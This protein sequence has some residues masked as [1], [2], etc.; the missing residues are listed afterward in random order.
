MPSSLTAFMSRKLAFASLSATTYIVLPFLDFFAPIASSRVH[1]LK[2]A[3]RPSTTKQPTSMPFRFNCVSHAFFSVSTSVV[4]A[5]ATLSSDGASKSSKA[6]HSV[7]SSSFANGSN[8]CD[9]G[10]TI[11]PGKVLIFSF[12]PSRWVISISKPHKASTREIFRSMKR[13]APFRLKSAC[14]CCF[15]TKITSPASASG[16]SSAISLK[17]TLCPSGEPFWMCTSR[18]SRSCF[19]LKDLPC[20]PQLSHGACICW[21]IGPIRMTSILTPRPSQMR[22]SDTP[23]FLSMTWRVMAIFFVAPAYICSRVTLRF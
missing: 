14:S 19:M 4:C 5:S 21:I 1:C 7:L 10:F 13:S 2:Y 23:F 11:S 16:C 8:P 20:P 15:S 18:T 6:S 17:G 9:M 22:H 3:P 12:L